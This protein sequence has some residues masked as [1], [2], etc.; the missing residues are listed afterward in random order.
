MLIKSTLVATVLLLLATSV[1]AQG[2]SPDFTP[3]R[4]SLDAV[5][6]QDCWDNRANTFVDLSP[7]YDGAGAQ[8]MEQTDFIDLTDGLTLTGVVAGKKLKIGF[9]RDSIGCV[10]YHEPL[11]SQKY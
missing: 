6:T 1:V 8:F 4:C 5:V 3:G 2:V 9:E 10:Y 7:I 11:I